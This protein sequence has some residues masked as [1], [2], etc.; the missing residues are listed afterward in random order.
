[1]PLDWSLRADLARSFLNHCTIGRRDRHFWITLKRSRRQSVINCAR[2]AIDESAIKAERVVRDGRK[3]ISPSNKSIFKSLN[4]VCTCGKDSRHRC[5]RISLLEK[6]K[7]L[8]QVPADRPTIDCW[9]TGVNCGVKYG[10]EYLVALFIFYFFF[11]LIK[12]A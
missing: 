12:A 3:Q 7:Q 6:C 1:M 4:C 9:R 11:L 10:D 5:A 8:R 2:F